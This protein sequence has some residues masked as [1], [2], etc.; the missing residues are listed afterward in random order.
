MSREVRSQCNRAQQFVAFR[1]LPSGGSSVRSHDVS[2]P[3]AK[4]KMGRYAEALQDIREVV[5]LQKPSPDK[6][7]IEA[8]RRL[9]ALEQVALSRF[10]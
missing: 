8:A 10:I 6:A 3:Q 7:A 4:E 9:T 1:E 5:R 2:T